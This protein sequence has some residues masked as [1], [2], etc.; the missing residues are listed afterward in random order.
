MNSQSCQLINFLFIKKKKKKKSKSIIFK[1]TYFS[2]NQYLNSED[3]KDIWKL[4]IHA[5]H[6]HLLWKMAWDILPTFVTINNRFSIPS[7]DC[8]LCKYAPKSLEHIF[9]KYDWVYQLW[10]LASWHLNLNN[11]NNVSIH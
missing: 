4:K 9:L 2:L 10:F 6:K 11:M 5:R 3:W 1:S 8:I 7:L